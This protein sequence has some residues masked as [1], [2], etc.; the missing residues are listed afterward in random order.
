MSWLKTIWISLFASLLYTWLFDT[1]VCNLTT[2]TFY[3]ALPLIKLMD[4][5][6]GQTLSYSFAYFLNFVVGV[7]LTALI[8]F[9]LA[10]LISDRVKLAVVSFLVV[11]PV[12]ILMLYGLN[13]LVS[14]VYQL[15]MVIQPIVGAV[16]F[17]I[18][19]QRIMSK[20]GS[21]PPKPGCIE[22]VA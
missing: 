17:L 6:C 13:W 1:V 5:C 3:G 21:Q 2:Y 18:A 9:P 14:N 15:S 19:A 16:I 22:N 10:Y 7:G 11:V 4:A 20:T 12:L 8:L